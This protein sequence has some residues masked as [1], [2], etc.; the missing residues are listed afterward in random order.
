MVPAENILCTS[1]ISYFVRI[2][3]IFKQTKIRTGLCKSKKS[4]LAQ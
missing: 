3:V 4:S 1:G 2:K